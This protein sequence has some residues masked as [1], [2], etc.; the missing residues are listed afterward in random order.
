MSRV[1]LASGSSFSQTFEAI[2]ACARDALDALPIDKRDPGFEYFPKGTCG[3]VTELMGRLVLERTGREGIYVCG[4]GHPCLSRQQTHAWLEVDGFIVDLTHDQFEG[5]GVNGWVLFDSPW[6]R[7]FEREEM[8]L[9]LHPANWMQ[10]PRRAYMAMHE[11]LSR[12]TAKGR[13]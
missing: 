11:A 9:C 10:Y 12:H 3:P 4:A 5:T 1:P 6:H 2:A 13:T 8:P 7:Q